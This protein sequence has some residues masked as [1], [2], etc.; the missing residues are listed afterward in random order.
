MLDHASPEAASMAS[1]PGGIARQF[2][3]Q[4]FSSDTPSHWKHV[5]SFAD[6]RDACRCAEALQDSGE[7]IRVVACRNLPTAA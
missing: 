6:L 1:C 4:I 7:Q 5:G 2:R 3:V